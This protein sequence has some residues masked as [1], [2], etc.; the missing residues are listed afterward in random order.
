MS[1]T[2]TSTLKTPQGFEITNAY[3][4]VAVQN[5]YTGD[6]IQAGV[7][8]FISEEAWA[9][10]DQPFEVAGGLNQGATAPYVYEPGTENILDIAHDLLI[11]SLGEQKV[12]AVKE[13][14]E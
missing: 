3:G 14:A 10:G 13:L 12:V 5:G 11:Q 6:N 9:A 8:F 7:Q 2:I 1:L 4:R